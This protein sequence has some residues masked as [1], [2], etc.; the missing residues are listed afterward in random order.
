MTYETLQYVDG[1][2]ATQE[3]AIQNLAMVNG[4]VGSAVRMWM[5]PKSHTWSEFHIVLPQPPEVAHAVPFLSQCVVYAC[6]QSTNGANNSF[7]GGS[8]LFQGRR[9]DNPGSASAEARKLTN[10]ILLCDALRDL[11]AITYQL[12][13]TYI[14]GYTGATPNYGTF[15]FPDII[16]FQESLLGQLQPNGTYA[17]YNP[18]PVQDAITTWQSIMHIVYYAINYLTGGPNAGASAKVQLQMG[19][20][21]EFTPSYCNT[22]QLR[23]AK[24]LD[25]ISICLR[26][27]PLVYTEV[28]YTVTPPKLHFRYVGNMTPVTLPYKSTDANGNVHIATDIASLPDLVPNRVA[29]FYQ[30]TSQVNGKP[31]VGYANDIY[32]VAGAPSLL[33]EVYSINVQG[34]SSQNVTKN[35]VSYAFNPTDLTLWR[36]KVPSLKQQSQGGQIPNDGNTGA[37]QFVS[38]AAYNSGSNPKGIQVIDSTGAAIDY[39]DTFLYWTDESVFDWFVA[40]GQAAQALKATVKGFFNYQRKTSIGAGANATTLNPNMLEH[41]HSLRLVLTNVPTGQYTLAQLL[42]TGEAIP[43]Q[44]AKNIYNELQW[45]QYN[46]KHVNWQVGKDANT[47]PALIKPGK[48]T[49]NLSGGLAAWQTMNAVPE[50]VTIEFFRVTQNGVSLL[51]A[52]HEIS[53]GPVDHLNPQYRVQLFNLFANRQLAQINPNQRVSGLSGGTDLTAEDSVENAVP[54]P[55]IPQVFTA[56]AVDSGTGTVTPVILDAAKVFAASQL[57]AGGA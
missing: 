19:T 15:Y 31:V 55:E 33:E 41:E 47:A 51:A 16:L 11:K 29:L 26:P 53:C 36:T 3:V 32:P 6:R 37:L 4:G 18:A 9:W 5:E 39:A 42:T 40:G 22:Y 45:L 54:S 30:I 20:T 13:W 8:I 14:T 50:S 35:F 38:S 27:H 57:N 25:A 2:G 28:D 21:P 44:L 10:E 49:I 46:L 56:A 43:V 24:C 12:D 1:N 17:P 34:P 48:N 52:R 7:S 23:A